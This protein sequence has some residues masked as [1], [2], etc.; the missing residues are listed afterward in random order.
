[1]ATG[2]TPEAGMVFRLPYTGGRGTSYEFS[3]TPYAKQYGASMAELNLE[4]KLMGMDIAAAQEE[5][6]QKSF[7]LSN[8]RE[9]RL[10]RQ[11]DLKSEAELRAE[12]RNARLDE[13]KFNEIEK[14]Q[15]REH[16]L[17]EL[18]SKIDDIDPMHKDAIGQLN[19]L[20]HDSTFTR[21]LA[22]PETRDALKN[23]LISKTSQIQDVVGGI[24]QEAKSKYGVN[25][26]LSQ[27]PTTEEGTWD[28]QK[29]YKEH[30]PAIAEQMRQ[31]A[32]TSYV[33]APEKPGYTKYK[34]MDAYGMPITKFVKTEDVNKQKLEE[35]RLS[36]GEQMQAI[37]AM[38]ALRKEVD[39][40]LGGFKQKTLENPTSYLNDNGKLTKDPSKAVFAVWKEKG[41]EVARIAES[42]RKD[43]LQKIESLSG[44]IQDWAS[45]ATPKK[46]SETQDRTQD[47]TTTPSPPVPAATPSESQS[48]NNPLTK[49]VLNSL[50]DE[51]G[52]TV[53]KENLMDL[54]R[55]R[56]YT[57]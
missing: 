17:A 50:A 52:P 53:T 16:D 4:E 27:F 28:L 12:A 11:Q 42:E 43:R 15:G 24:Q 57:F 39:T 30:L 35:M 5:R 9:A 45:I 33:T 41:K 23:A 2:G 48:Q 22:H 51:L 46:E 55:K 1:M 13:L 6:A 21:M 7:D 19:E 44:Q 36:R 14:K 3:Q 54:A 29:G 40:T 20:R 56:G 49:E 47:T 25:A 18:S 10:Q 26:D 8:L 38:Q 31:R 37:S 34:E 32:E